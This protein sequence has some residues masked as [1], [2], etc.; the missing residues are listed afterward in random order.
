MKITTEELHELLE[1]ARSENN[2][3][4][5]H[6]NGLLEKE[7]QVYTERKTELINEVTELLDDSDNEDRPTIEM[8]LTLI[9]H[10]L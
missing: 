1:L 7:R 4:I 2:L 9:K 5:N 10:T 6:I 8:V 3:K